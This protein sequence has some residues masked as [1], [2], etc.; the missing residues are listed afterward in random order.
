MTLP[1]RCLTRRATSPVS[2]ARPA[3]RLARAP[4]APPRLALGRPGRL[5]WLKQAAGAAASSSIAAAAPPLLRC[6]GRPS[7]AARPGGHSPPHPLQPS[8]LGAE[9]LNSLHFT[10]STPTEP[11]RGSWRRTAQCAAAGTTPPTAARPPRPARRLRRGA[12]ARGV[13]PRGPGLP[14]AAHPQPARPHPGPAERQLRCPVRGEAAFHA[15]T[16]RR[17]ADRAP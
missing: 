3:A 9:Q 6:R 16:A 10:T 2:P 5:T 17:L 4:L 12:G 1:T 14:A 8:N 15:I 7:A 11:E 13:R